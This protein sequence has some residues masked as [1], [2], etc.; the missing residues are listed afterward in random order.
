MVIEETATNPTGCCRYSHFLKGSNRHRAFSKTHAGALHGLCSKIIPF[1]SLSVALWQVFIKLKRHVNNLRSIK[2]YALHKP[3]L[4]L[5]MACE[6][7]KVRLL[8]CLNCS[9]IPRQGGD[10]VLAKDIPSDAMSMNA[11]PPLDLIRTVSEGGGR[12]HGRYVLLDCFAQG[13]FSCLLPCTQHFRLVH[14]CYHSRYALKEALQGARV[15]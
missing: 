6:Q 11:D 13:P 15:T 1:A 12:W 9:R 2:A 7:S 14:S 8:I 4:Q 3:Q 10:K 5:L